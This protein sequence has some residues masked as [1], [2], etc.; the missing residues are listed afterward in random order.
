MS[1]AAY[2]LQGK[3]N[4]AYTRVIPLD[5]K[6]TKVA[7]TRPG[8]PL[9]AA[10]AHGAAS[11]RLP[12]PPR[13]S[14]GLLAA[15]GWLCAHLSSQFD[16]RGRRRR[17]ARRVQAARG[18]RRHH[19]RPGAGASRAAPGRA[20]RSAAAL[21]RAVEWWEGGGQARGPVLVAAAHGRREGGG[22]CQAGGHGGA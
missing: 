19:V 3:G 16:A 12:R 4:C 21:R 7:T 13:S 22:S 17:A 18:R 2:K 15:L 10:D 8:S 11:C 1:H 6:A 5:A 9:R 20:L 14:R